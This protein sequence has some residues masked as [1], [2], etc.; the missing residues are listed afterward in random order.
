MN[1]H[2]KSAALLAATA[3]LLV[4]CGVPLQSEPEPL[5]SDVV[6]TSLHVEVPTASPLPSR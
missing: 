1:R 5:E 2:L 6:P 3:M 4:G